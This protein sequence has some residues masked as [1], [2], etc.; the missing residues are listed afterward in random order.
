M[1]CGIDTV[2]EYGVV[3]IGHIP[4]FLV[5]APTTLIAINKMI[6]VGADKIH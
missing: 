2:Q 4:D 5:N 6:V 1:E 3:D